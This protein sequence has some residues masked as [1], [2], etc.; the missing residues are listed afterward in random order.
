MSERRVRCRTLSATSRPSAR[1]RARKT[2]PIPPS[3]AR[4]RISK[5]SAT[6]PP[7]SMRRE[8][9]TLR[10]VGEGGPLMGDDYEYERGRVFDVRTNARCIFIRENDMCGVVLF[11]DRV[12][13]PETKPVED[14]PRR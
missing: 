1:S 2:A 4:S 9:L 6:T 11:P 3:P 14:R 7:G 8:V 13:D 12:Q 5:R 10:E